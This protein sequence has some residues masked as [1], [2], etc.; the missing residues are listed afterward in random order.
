MEDELPMQYLYI[1]YKD[2]Q[3]KLIEES[4]DYIIRKHWIKFNGRAKRNKEIL[5]F[6]NDLHYKFDDWCAIRIST[7][8][9][10]SKR[11]D[12]ISEEELEKI[13]AM[14][15]INKLIQ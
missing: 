4:I 9:I 13:T 10:I 11:L 8:V 15:V 3:N 1:Q 2:K 5:R 12:L 6:V 14:M 7:Y